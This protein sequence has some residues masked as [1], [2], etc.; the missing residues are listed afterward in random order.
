[1]DSG[2]T[3]N[4]ASNLEN[5]QWGTPQ[6]F[7]KV[8]GEKKMSQSKVLLWHQRFKNVMNHWKTNSAEDSWEHHGSWTMCD[9]CRRLCIWLIVGSENF[10]W[11]LAHY[12]QYG[13]G[14]ALYQTTHHTKYANAAGNNPGFLH[15]I[16]TSN[17]I[18]CLL[19]IPKINYSPQCG[20]CHYQEARSSGRTAW[21][22]RWWEKSFT[23]GRVLCTMSLL[24]N[25]MVNMFFPVYVRQFIWS[26]LK[27][28][29]WKTGVPARKY[30]STLFTA[31]TTA[32]H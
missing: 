28:G 31:Y 16:I 19:S 24:L 15:T 25:T 13:S 1:M 27:G 23:N 12:P 30:P 9:R 10:D 2:L 14:D 29:L 26:V 5:C 21:S 22:G 17:K 18:Y 8:S 20:S 4:S 3:S 32:I 11:S 6:I 7:W